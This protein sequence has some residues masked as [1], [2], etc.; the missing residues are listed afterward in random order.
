MLDWVGKRISTVS[1]LANGFA[2]Y[3]VGC[4]GEVTGTTGSKINISLDP[5]PHCG[6]RPFIRK[7]D[8]ADVEEI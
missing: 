1:V 7:V 5:C 8:V 4:E 6:I 2:K 3:P